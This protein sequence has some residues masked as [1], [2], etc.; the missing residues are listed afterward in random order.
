MST[1]V[2]F[3]GGPHHLDGSSRDVAPSGSGAVGLLAPHALGP[4][5]MVAD[6]VVAVDSGLHLARAFD[7]NVDLVIG[8][9]DSVDPAVLEQAAASG[10]EVSRFPADKD[11]TDLELALDE[12]ASRG[13]TAVTV[14]GSGEGRLDHLLGGL[15]T[16]AAPRFSTMRI[17][18]WL[19]S[20]YVC[21]VHDE[22][23]IV[24]APGA[25]LSILPVNGTASGVRTSGLRWPLRG[26]QLAPGSSRGVSNEF[27]DEVA[28]VSVDEGC[29]VVVVPQEEQP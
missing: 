27:L 28:H 14:I 23:R 2:V 24:G 13:V 11:F 1:A 10:A 20:A 6:L 21:V 18:A 8:D 7:L 12:V 26:E 19:G 3:A 16:L 4:L 22:R 17:D 5:L 15:L 25:L 9:M 29:V